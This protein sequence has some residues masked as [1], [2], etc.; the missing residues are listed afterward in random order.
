MGTG[1]RLLR[2]GLHTGTLIW[3]E[4]GGALITASGLFSPLQAHK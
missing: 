1:L 3:I 4:R 2:A